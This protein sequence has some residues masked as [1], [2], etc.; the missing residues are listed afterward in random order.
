[1]LAI[2]AVLWYTIYNICVMQICRAGRPCGFTEMAQY[3]ME[4]KVFYG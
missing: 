3:D 1:M 2:S 4:G